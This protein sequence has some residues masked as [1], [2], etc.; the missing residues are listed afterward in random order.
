MAMSA[1]VIAIV[2]EVQSSEEMDAEIARVSKILY[3]PILSLQASR[4]EVSFSFT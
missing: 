4:P 1:K 3:E 2:D